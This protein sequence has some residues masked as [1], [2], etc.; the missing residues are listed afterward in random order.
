MFAIG[1]CA[2]GY[3]TGEAVSRSFSLKVNLPIL[4]AVSVSPDVDMIFQKFSPLIHRGPTHSLITMTILT[5]PFLLAYGKVVAPYF[6]ALISHSLIGDFFTGGVQLF[7][8]I[9]QNWYGLFSM[10][11][12]SFTV[13]LIELILFVVSIVAMVKSG[14]L[15]RLLQPGSKKVALFLPL[16]ALLVPMLPL[17]SGFGPA[18]PQLLIIPSLI[19]MALFS[20]S[21][22]VERKKGLRA[23]LR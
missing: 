17:G 4:L 7:W 9:D 22:L 16:G 8:P 12:D 15:I 1:H 10:E 21:I 13:A 14:A 11:G 6:V 20:Y 23:L 19:Y 3:L 5:I 18:L 2:L